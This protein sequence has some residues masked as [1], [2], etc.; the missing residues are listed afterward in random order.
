[1]LSCEDAYL[2]ASLAQS[3]DPN[4]ILAIGPIPFEGQDKTFPGSGGFKVYA[5]KAPNSRGVARVLTRLNGGKPPLEYSAFL[6]ELRKNAGMDAIIL[7]GNYPSNWATQDLAKALISSP[8]RFVVLVDTLRTNLTD[9]AD[10]V[11]PC[12]TWA[13]KSGVFENANNRLQAFERAIAPIDYTKSESQIAIDLAAMQSLDSGLPGGG[14]LLN[15]GHIRQQ[16][17]ARH[18]LSEFVENVHHP[19]A[20]HKVESDMQLMPL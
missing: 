19:A 15:S 2:L 9:L 10:V 18:G 6:A 11:I 4:A 17:A 7:T 20:E 1:M 13:E 8:G 5:E 12:A 14:A 16:M 3:H